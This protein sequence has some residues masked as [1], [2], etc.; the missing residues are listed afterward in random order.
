[1]DTGND[2]AGGV[3]AAEKI[4]MKRKKSGRIEYRVKWKGWTARYNTWEPEENIL[5]TRLIHIF[6]RSLPNSP[7]KRGPKKKERFT[8]PDPLTED[9]DEEKSADDTDTDTK[10]SI[11]E[12]R[13]IKEEKELKKE[14][15]ESGKE[16][17]KKDKKK[18][19]HHNASLPS[20]SAEVKS[21]AR[22]KI[23]PTGK[24][25]GINK[26]WLSGSSSPSAAVSSSK[27]PAILAE[28][29]TNSSSSE[30]QPLSH[31]EICGTKRKAEVL[32]KESGKIG[33]TIKTS[34]EQ[35]PAA[36][37]ACCESAASVVVLEKHLSAPLSPETPASHPESDTPPIEKANDDVAMV[38]VLEAAIPAAAAAPSSDGHNQQLPD[39]QASVKEATINNNNTMKKLPPVPVSPRAAPPRLWLPKARKHDQVFITDVTVNLETV[40]IRECKTE[41]GFFRERDLK[42]DHIIN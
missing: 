2:E 41:R 23:E 37:I 33:V 31:K 22:I 35:P 5:D 14:K 29:D 9:E 1:M 18:L 19:S 21:E 28:V 34:P 12:E 39:Q 32:S 11:K 26:N 6:E 38:G 40:T 4:I 30:D 24:E 36:K 42:H 16:D 13:Q 15:R 17:T 8:E 27:L 10:V 25:S 7:A 20:T 3:Y